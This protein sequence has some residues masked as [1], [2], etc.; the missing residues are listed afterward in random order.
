MFPHTGAVT[1]MCLGLYVSMCSDE[2]DGNVLLP[3]GDSLARA[4]QSY[5][6]HVGHGDWIAHS[7][8]LSDRLFLCFFFFFSGKLGQ[9][10]FL[11]CC[12]K[13]ARRDRRRFSCSTVTVLTLS[14]TSNPLLWECH[15]KRP[16]LRTYWLFFVLNTRGQMARSII[17]K[18]HL[19]LCLQSPAKTILAYCWNG[20]LCLAQNRGE[21]KVLLDKSCQSAQILGAPTKC[22]KETRTLSG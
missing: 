6:T 18:R 7:L 1:H 11:S 2:W 3:A 10:R 15:S 16:L 5:R 9:L 4:E 22:P 12:E 14:G 20:C 13:K 8:S 17:C 21:L 19:A